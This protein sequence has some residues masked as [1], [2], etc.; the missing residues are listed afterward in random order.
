MNISL[1]PKAFI[2]KAR[3]YLVHGKVEKSRKRSTSTLPSNGQDS[4]SFKMILVGP[5][6]IGIF[7]LM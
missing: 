5:F 2:P 6:Q 4:S 7:Y 3:L 1:Q